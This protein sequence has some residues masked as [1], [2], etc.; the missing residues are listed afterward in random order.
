M[1]QVLLHDLMLKEVKC[2]IFGLMCILVCHFIFVLLL[3][4]WWMCILVLKFNLSWHFFVC[5]FLYEVFIFCC[6]LWLHFVIERVIVLLCCILKWTLYHV[7][8]R[9]FKFKVLQTLCQSTYIL[10]SFNEIIRHTF[11]QSMYLYSSILPIVDL[12]LT[13]S[14]LV[15]YDYQATFYISIIWNKFLDDNCLN[16]WFRLCVFAYLNQH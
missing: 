12:W 5:L 10:H 1:K 9:N 7:H 2:L 3:H 15:V 13:F 14:K 11:W 4:Q 8:D 16:E 6:W